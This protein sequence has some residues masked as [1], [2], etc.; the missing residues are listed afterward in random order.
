MDGWHE[1]EIRV[2]Y[3]ETD[4]MGIVHHSNYLIWFESGRSD[5]CR[6]KGFSYKA[7]EEEDNALM[8]V[9]ESYVRYKSPAFY[10][11]VLTV[12]TQ[13]AEVRSRSIRFIYEVYR[14]SDETLIAEG[15]TLHLV[16]DENKK[17]RIVPEIYR[18]LLLGD[19]ALAAFP[20]NQPP[21]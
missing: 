1:T 3:A 17:V 8:V 13:V 20:A 16:T 19:A 2:R 18:Q 15:E 5:L 7:M 6:S 21:H 4:K 11:D 9:A 10:E 12:R 14:A